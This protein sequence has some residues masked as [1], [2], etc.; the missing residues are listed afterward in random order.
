LHLTLRN[1]YLKAL[2]VAGVVAVSEADTSYNSDRYRK[3]LAEANDETKRLAFIHLL[4]EEK[5]KE[6][7]AN[8]RLRSRPPGLD[9]MAA[10]SQRKR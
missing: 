4:I 9:K 7:L 5:A 6:R 3:L 2:S 10:L 8:H 1:T